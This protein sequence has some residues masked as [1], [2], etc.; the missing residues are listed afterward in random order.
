MMAMPA[1]WVTW[2]VLAAAA[3]GLTEVDVPPGAAVAEKLA[4][5]FPGVTDALLSVGTRVMQGAATFMGAGAKSAQ[6]AKS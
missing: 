5:L 3:F 1:R 4:S 2:A 6:K